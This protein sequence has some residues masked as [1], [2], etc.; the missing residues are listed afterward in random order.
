MTRFVHLCI[1]VATTTFTAATFAVPAI[2]EDLRLC[3]SAK[4]A[5]DAGKYSHAISLYN[6]C[7]NEGNL[8]EASYACAVLSRGRC[9]LESGQPDKGVGDVRSAVLMHPTFGEAKHAAHC[10][11]TTEAAAE[12]IL[13]AEE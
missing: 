12:A 1:L 9:Y 7:I 2:A 4:Q 5:F 13:S 11:E 10:L 8:S 6:Q 3:A